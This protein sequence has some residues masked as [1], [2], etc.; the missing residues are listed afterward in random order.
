MTLGGYGGCYAATVEIA[1]STL[2]ARIDSAEVVCRDISVVYPPH[3]D[4][5]AKHQIVADLN[6]AGVTIKVV[7]PLPDEEQQV[8]EVIEVMRRHDFSPEASVGWSN[9]IDGA[10]E[11]I[12]GSLQEALYRCLE[13]D[14]PIS[15]L[16]EYLLVRT[17]E[18]ALV[19]GISANE[20]SRCAG[21]SYRQALLDQASKANAGEA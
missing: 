1:L 13:A 20:F 7:R 8:V 6:S 17:G 5:P 19:A 2:R 3:P 12:M 14:L 9:G 10:D 21:S 16:V 11:D 4:D 15:K 18:V